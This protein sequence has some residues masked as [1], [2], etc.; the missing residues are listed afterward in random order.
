MEAMGHT[1]ENNYFSFDLHNAA[2]VQDGDTIS[3]S[4]AVTAT[5]AN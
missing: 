1:Y 5:T 3:V 4:V 2:E